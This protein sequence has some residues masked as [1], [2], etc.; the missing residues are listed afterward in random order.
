M[1]ELRG[2]RTRAGSGQDPSC[3]LKKLSDG[4]EVE[5]GKLYI[6]RKWR[7]GEQDWTKRKSCEVASNIKIPSHPQINALHTPA[8]KDQEEGKCSRI[9]V[10]L[11]KKGVWNP[12]SESQEANTSAS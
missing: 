9:W 8:L 2:M 12:L 4:R 7:K 11:G 3:I 10:W 1:K 6:W 5:G